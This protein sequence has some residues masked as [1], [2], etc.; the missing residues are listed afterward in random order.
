MLS[1]RSSR[2]APALLKTAAATRASTAN[3]ANSATRMSR[4]PTASSRYPVP[5]AP[6]ELAP[7]TRSMTT[8]P[9]RP[10]MSLG[11]MRTW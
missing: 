10:C 11:V 3:T 4:L 8:P 7:D 1:A 9:T 6:S 5:S 2:A